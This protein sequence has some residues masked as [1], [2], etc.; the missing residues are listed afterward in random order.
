MCAPGRGIRYL[1]QRAEA[2]RLRVV[3]VV[4]LLPPL[5]GPGHL[6]A[7]QHLWQGEG[8]WQYEGVTLEVRHYLALVAQKSSPTHPRASSTLQARVG[9]YIDD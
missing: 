8:R 4:L 3:V 6:E 2:L 7:H 1:D 5:A 9:D